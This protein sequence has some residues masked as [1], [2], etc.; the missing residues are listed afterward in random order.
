MMKLLI[1]C[2]VFLL[3]VAGTAHSAVLLTE[4][5]DSIST[6][7]GAGWVQTNNS[8]PT[9][10]TGWFQGNT[11]IFSAQGGAADAYIAANF[12]NADSGGNISNWL[13]T[14]TLTLN[15][16]DVIS[17]YTR[18]EDPALFADRLEVRLSTSGISSDVGSTD[19]SVGD[20]T[21]LLL[22]IN[23]TLVGDGYPEAWTQFT[24]TLSGLGVDTDGRLAFR[25]FV[26]D[27]S[28]NANYIGI[29]TVLIE[30]ASTP[31]PEP[32]TLAFLGFGITS[33]GFLRRRIV[34]LK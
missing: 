22:T 34:G 28:V 2:L 17:F 1:R 30:S 18:T 19:S 31:V 27:T 9:G 25:Y 15:D 14:P 3:M 23:P 13:L 16:G 21:T 29:D 5:F 4:N 33:L 7:P 26:P 10:A 6:L 12:L 20:F 11:G 32:S 24:L 8:S